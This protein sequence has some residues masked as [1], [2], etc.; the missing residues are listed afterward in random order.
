MVGWKS[1]KRSYQ[2]ITIKVGIP[3]HLRREMTMIGREHWG[4]FWA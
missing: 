2:V 1:H 3:A 4:R